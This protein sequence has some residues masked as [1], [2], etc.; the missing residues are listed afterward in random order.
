MKKQNLV[1]I[2]A[3]LVAIVSLGF[4]AMKAEQNETLEQKNA[5]Q[6]KTIAFIAGER[7][8]LKD[9]PFAEKIINNKHVKIQYTEEEDGYYAITIFDKNRGSYFGEVKDL[10]DNNMVGVDTKGFMVLKNYIE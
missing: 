4:G 1:T 8:K 5:E 2:T 3:T 10:K 9:N 6:T 7:D